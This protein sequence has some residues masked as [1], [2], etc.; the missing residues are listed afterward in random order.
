MPWVQL[1]K[2]ALGRA[3]AEVEYSAP[4]LNAFRCSPQ[5]NGHW[6]VGCLAVGMRP[7]ERS[8]T[9]RLLRR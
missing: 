8:P 1:M 4:V 9:R 7:G 3:G 2:K 5:L 6:N